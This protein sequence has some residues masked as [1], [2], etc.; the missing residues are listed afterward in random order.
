MF[1]LKKG[2]PEEDE[3]VLCRVTK[4]LPNSVFA[5]L[6]EYDNKTGMLHIS[7]VSPG[8]IRNIRDYVVEGKVIVCKVLRVNPE[9]GH[10][11]LSLR[12]VSES[13]RRNKIDS[14]KKEQIAEKI[15][16][17]IAKKHKLDTKQF[18]L[19]ISR[20]ILDEYGSLYACFEDFVEG[21][22]E[23]KKKGIPEKYVKEFETL[24][25]QRIK[26]P[27][28]L[29]EG[30][31]VLKSHEP[32][33]VEIVMEA[34]KKAEEITGEGSIRYMGAG[35][36]FVSVTRNDPMEAESLIKKASEAAISHMKACRSEGDF[37]RK[38]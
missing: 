37:I 36:Y 15:V 10:I 25:R 35:K 28:Y 13:Q 1:F 11:D 5:S 26:L 21:N 14:L 23:L 3:I 4:V 33:G 18:Y 38:N 27:E 34:L 29:L 20:K 32:N 2:D 12:R 24:I 19:D 16:E 9:R 6:E 30:F 31:I 8:R 22:A 7:E 17:F